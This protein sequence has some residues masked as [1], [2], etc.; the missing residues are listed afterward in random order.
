MGPVANTAIAAL[1]GGAAAGFLYASSSTDELPAVVGY[2]AGTLMIGG[3]ATLAV[4]ELVKTPG[5]AR[6]VPMGIGLIVGGTALLGA[7]LLGQSL[8]GDGK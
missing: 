2:T 8:F 5:M 7:F 4:G 1:G 3:A 6:H